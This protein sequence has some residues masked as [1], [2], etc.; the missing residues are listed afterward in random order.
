MREKREESIGFEAQ[1][2][3]VFS[4]IGLF[5]ALT[6]ALGLIPGMR[7]T[8]LASD[9]NSEVK[10]SAYDGAITSQNESY[11]Y[12]FDG[13]TQ[14]KWCTCNRGTPKNESAYCYYVEFSSNVPITVD[15]YFLTTANDTDTHGGR[16][17]KS[18]YLKAKRNSDESWT[19]I[20]TV[21][22]DEVM[23]AASY[24]GYSFD[25][26]VTGT[27]QYFLFMVIDTKGESTLQLSELTLNNSS[28]SSNTKTEA[29]I[30][31][32]TE[33]VNKFCDD[34]PFTVKLNN[35]GDGKV[36]Y[37]SDNESVAKV[38]SSTGEVEI[39]SSY[40][41]P[42]TITAT[43]ED[44]DNFEYPVKT[45]KYKLNINQHSISFKKDR[46]NVV[47]KG[48]NFSN[49]LINDGNGIDNM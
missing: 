6:M 10:F 48:E 21:T 9:T 22:N 4:L 18:W 3:L 33:T 36:T 12:L 41:K 43:V 26:D 16:N 14:T 47:Y 8:A 46:I 20:D 49:E 7:L 45:A 27:W 24:T 25:V 39:L 28:N 2:R 34:K 29:S 42:V 13:N 37:T 19:T 30:E 44:S 15:K 17:P 31:F 40:Y 23:Q 35:T 1:N 32:E 38:N 11:I 5:I